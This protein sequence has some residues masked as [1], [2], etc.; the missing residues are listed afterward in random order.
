MQD[1]VVDFKARFAP[2]KGNGISKFE[3]NPKLYCYLSGHVKRNYKNCYEVPMLNDTDWFSGHISGSAPL[4]AVSSNLAF[5]VAL[6]ADRIDSTSGVSCKIALGTGRFLLQNHPGDVKQVSIVMHTV[7][8]ETGGFAK[9]LVEI[10]LSQN[11]IGLIKNVRFD[12]IL[13][14]PET[15]RS[16]L[17]TYYRKIEDMKQNLGETLKGTTN[18]DAPYDFSEAGF[19]LKS[20]IRLPFLSFALR[21]LPVTNADMWENAL[22]VALARDGFHVH[23]YNDYPQGPAGKARIMANMMTL[24]P[25]YYDYTADIVLKDVK[26]DGQPRN[27]IGTKGYLCCLFA[28][29]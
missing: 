13:F 24:I 28:K 21:D 11:T 9:A 26:G 15:M 22:K 19:G 3:T 7:D 8:S 4:G 10:Q 2:D 23:N 18:M 5:C 29:R 6:F 16:D 27:N 1:I 12:D 20:G 25:S 17:E 14:D